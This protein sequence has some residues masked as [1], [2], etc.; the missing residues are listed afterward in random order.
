[1]ADA[2]IDLLK[3][4][5]RQL[6]LPTMG[7]EFERLARMRPKQTR[8]SSSS[9]SASLRPSWQPGPLMQLR[10]GSGM[11]SS[12]SCVISTHTTSLLCRSSHGYILFV[13]RCGPRRRIGGGPVHHA[14]LNNLER[15][16]GPSVPSSATTSSWL[17]HT[18]RFS[19]RAE[20]C[21]RTPQLRS[22]L[23]PSQLAPR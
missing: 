15:L 19:Q 5:F 12:R 18:P 20:R 7:R 21:C 22:T 1:M 11:Q 6:R 8:T 16:A 17:D 3:A 9:C 23:R 2:V 4:H 14:G 13:A 10:R